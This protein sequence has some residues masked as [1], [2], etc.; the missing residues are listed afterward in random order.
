MR[1][2][3]CDEHNVSTNSFRLMELHLSREHSDYAPEPDGGDR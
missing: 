1:H 3:Q 2:Y